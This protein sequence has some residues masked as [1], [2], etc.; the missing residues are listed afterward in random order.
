LFHA[1]FARARKITPSIDAAK[2]ALPEGAARLSLLMGH[3]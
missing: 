2:E 3:V 1:G